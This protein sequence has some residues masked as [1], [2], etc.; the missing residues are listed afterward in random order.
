M[1]NYIWDELNKLDGFLHI[2][3]LQD[4]Q[5]KREFWILGGVVR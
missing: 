3:K 2:R 5:P 1:D 4:Q